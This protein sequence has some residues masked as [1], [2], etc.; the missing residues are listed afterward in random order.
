M[1][2][3]LVYD[4]INKLGGAERILSALHQIWPKAPIYTAVYN[5]KTATWA[6][7]I[8]IK[9]S[10][11]NFWPWAKTHHELYP[12]LT[13]LA[14]ESFDFS[15]YDLII[16]VTSAEAKAIITPP[17]C[18]HI[19]YCLTPT[20]YLWSHREQYLNDSGLGFWF[21]FF[22]RYLQ[23]IDLINSSRPDLYL[24]ISKTVQARIKKYYQRPSVLIYPPL[25]FNRFYFTSVKDYFLIVSRLVDYKKIDIAI[26]AANQLKRKLVI[27]GRGRS[28]KRLVKI[29]G[30]TIEFKGQVSEPELINYYSHC[31]ALIMPQE[32]DFGLAA[33]EAQASGKPVIAFA[34][35]GALETVIPG[36]TG[37][38]FSRQTVDSLKQAMKQFES[39]NWDHSLIRLH[40][41]KFNLSNFKRQ[42]KKIVEVEWQQHRQNFL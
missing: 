30:P 27:V 35:G 36:K 22:F 40:A 9:S 42:F 41:Q 20:R 5:P 13:A 18:L 11:L 39:F 32:E 15:D 23:K 19:C 2:I 25:D 10:F 16:S 28:L 26:K 6:K 4:R 17:S 7:R 8:T 1:K 38:L 14:F 31:R 37:L 3:A 29:S 33:L 34:A 12:W 24:A 21:K